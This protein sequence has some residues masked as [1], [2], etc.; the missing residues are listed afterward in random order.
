M[1]VY[2]YRLKKQ[3]DEET[4][5]RGV[6][7]ILED[8]LE[9]GHFHR[10]PSEIQVKTDYGTFPLLNKDMLSYCY[11]DGRCGYYIL[12]APYKNKNGKE[13]YLKAGRGRFPY[14]FD[15]KYEAIH[16]FNI[17]KDAQYLNSDAINFK[18]AKF[19]PYTFG[20]EFESSSGYIPEDICIRDGL[21]PLRDGS[22]T[23]LEYST[24]VLK[25]V[26]GLNLLKQQLNT[27]DKYTVYDKECSLHM[28]IGVPEVDKYFIWNLYVLLVVFQNEL[29]KYVPLWTFESNRYK[30]TRKNYCSK[31]PKAEDF[32][33]WYQFIAG[34]PFRGNLTDPH[35]NDPDRT[36]KWNVHSRYFDF[37]FV[38]LMCYDSPKTIEFRFLRPTYNFAEIETW[39]FVFMGLISA[40]YNTCREITD[41][42][43]TPV[44]NHY[45]KKYG[46]KDILFNLFNDVYPKELSSNLKDKMKIINN[47]HASYKVIHDHAGLNQDIKTKWY[48]NTTFNTSL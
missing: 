37:N 15:Q 25:D 47:V 21:I 42:S 10:N 16:S 9:F 19:L 22:I 13:V 7:R 29:S 30:A 24:V 31:I 32:N 46:K 20:L 23:G 2:D 17:F 39:L 26:F 34:E 6:V 45:Q 40:A 3:V 18:Y 44:F 11:F 36:H 1:L 43:F 41:L 48:Q 12:S 35:K 5:V 38:N 14:S 27:L 33:Q 8:S 28:H 4:T